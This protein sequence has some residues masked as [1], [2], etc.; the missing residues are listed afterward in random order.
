MRKAINENPTV[1]IAVVG[2]LVVVFGFLLV[3]RVMK[4]DE[5]PP[6]VPPNAPIGADATA[7][8]APTGTTAPA[9]TGTPTAGAVSTE[10]A[11]VTAASSAPVTADPATVSPEALVP[12]PGL[13]APVKRAWDRGDTVVLLVIRNS[14]TDDRLVR[15]LL[16]TISEPG[17]SV[18]VAKA[19]NIARYS[20]IT[21]GVGVTRVPALVVVRPRRISGPIPEA[22]V[23]YGFRDRESILQAVNDARYKGPD[24]LP[25]S[26]G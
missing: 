7:A 4:K 5:K 1:Q 24:D 26:P 21:Q 19:K 13:P 22:Q 14:A 11:P 9:P 16:D 10:A 17:T 8:P 12:G 25:Y 23:S 3:T 20:R 2:V 6:P 18:F 15:I